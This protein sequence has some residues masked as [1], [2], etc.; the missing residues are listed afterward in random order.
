VR[1][2]PFWPGGSVPPPTGRIYDRIRSDGNTV[3]DQS[4]DI[5]EE[6]IYGLLGFAS[7]EQEA[8]WRYG[9]KPAL[10]SGGWGSGKTW[11]G[12]SKA[13]YLSTR[14]KHNRGAIIRNNAGRCP[15][16][17]DAAGLLCR[18]ELAGGPAAA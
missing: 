4:L 12:C 3:S 2:C 11:L 15:R 16:C 1:E 10:M 17:A 13:V 18:P 14:Y 6:S 7:A 5:R 9:P 8:A